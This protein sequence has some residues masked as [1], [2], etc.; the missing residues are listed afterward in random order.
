M[1]ED[2]APKPPKPLEVEVKNPRYEGA[3]IEIVA[4]ALLRRPKKADEG[5]G[6]DPQGDA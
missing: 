4:G 5:D 2:P 3:T 6:G 1:S